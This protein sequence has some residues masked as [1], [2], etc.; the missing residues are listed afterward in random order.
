MVISLKYCVNKINLKAQER[1]VKIINIFNQ[2][3]L[4]IFFLR[5]DTKLFFKHLKHAPSNQEPAKN[6]D[7]SDDDGDKT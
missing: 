7:R 1:R 5:V 4:K 6:V 3:E 2:E